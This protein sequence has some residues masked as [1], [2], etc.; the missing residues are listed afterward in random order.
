MVSCLLARRAY[1]LR[2]PIL[3]KTDKEISA[4]YDP[5]DP[6]KPVTLLDAEGKGRLMEWHVLAPGLGVV[7]SKMYWLEKS[8][9]RQMRIEFEKDPPRYMTVGFNRK[10]KACC[11]VANFSRPAEFTRFLENQALWRKC[12][13]T[14]IL[15]EAFPVIKALE[16]RTIKVPNLIL[17]E[18]GTLVLGD[19]RYVVEH[20]KE[21]AR[22]TCHVRYTS[23]EGAY[24]VYIEK[25][26][27]WERTYRQKYEPILIREAIRHG[28]KFIRK[29]PKPPEIE[30]C[31][32]ANADT[33]W[34]MVLSELV[35]RFATDASAP[36]DVSRYEGRYLR[37]LSYEEAAI[38]QLGG[39]G[40]K[41]RLHAAITAAIR[42]AN[43]S[44]DTLE[45]NVLAAA[46]H[47]K[48]GV[49]TLLLSLID[50]LPHRARDRGIWMLGIAHRTSA[51]QAKKMPESV[52][53]R[54]AEL[55][56][57]FDA[58][59]NGKLSPTEAQDARLHLSK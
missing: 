26:D 31:L 33:F 59:E 10:G 51:T 36:R 7:S 13:Q 52:K 16:V 35:N 20:E 2:R 42:N 22:I 21:R 57:R 34:S 5:V 14:H 23:T 40:I 56:R 11:A 45:H 32:M 49:V 28:R 29:D 39:D 48:A 50:R 43:V 54:I 1:A 18:N 15:Q 30:S 17:D 55:Q 12:S 24:A 9:N 53:Q 27:T 25:Q 8:E 58:D 3:G 44:M 4:H 6:A 19:P 47:E 41:P 37:E 46:K 38:Q